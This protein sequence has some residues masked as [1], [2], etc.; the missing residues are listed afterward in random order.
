MIHHD[1][2]LTV[3]LNQNR[4]MKRKPEEGCGRRECS[5]GFESR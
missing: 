4:V 5:G 1:N 2:H 3:K